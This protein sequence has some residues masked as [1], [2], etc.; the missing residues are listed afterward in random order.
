MDDAPIG[1]ASR[2]GAGIVGLA[3]GY[4]AAYVPY[5]ALVK[6]LSNGDVPGTEGPVGG[7]VLLPAAALG[8]LAA[9][10]VFLS[11]AGWWRYAHRRTIAGRRVVT[12]GPAMLRASLWTALIV[13]ATTLN[14]TFPGASILLMLLLMR[15]GVLI[16]APVMDLLRR[17]TVRAASWAALG[18]SLA[19]VAVA[20]GDVEG[21]GLGLG[22]ALSVGLYLAGYAGRFAVMSAVAKR[23]E[24]ERDR[25]YFVDEHIGT[26]VV[27][28]LLCAVPAAVGAGAWGAELREGFTGFLLTPAAV[29]AFLVGVLYEAVFVLGTWIYLDR[30]E[31]TWAVPAN[32]CASLL[33]GVVASFGLTALAGLPRPGDAELLALAF[34]GAAS[35]VLALPGAGRGGTPPERPDR[36]ARLAAGRPGGGASR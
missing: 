30:R 9:M 33:A 14:Y 7:L 35:A 2:A 20:L 6:A 10:P 19:A 15:G 1:K 23:G 22:A 24:R 21:Y 29:P 26:P 16:L 31:F 28:V 36:P 18:L 13:G 3:A 27:L 25:R 8:Q 34:I 5:S 17:R 11:V 32:R 12:P 4:F